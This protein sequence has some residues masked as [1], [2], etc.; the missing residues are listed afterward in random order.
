M[1]PVAIALLDHI[2][3]KITEL[4]SGIQW[5][6]KHHTTSVILGM[7]KSVEDQPYMYLTKTSSI[8][9]VGFGNRYI[10]LSNK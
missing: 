8:L 10:I 6:D 4:S 2:L 7:N 3:H 5:A 1:C 9:H